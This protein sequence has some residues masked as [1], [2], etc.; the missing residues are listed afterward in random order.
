MPLGPEIYF[1]K[2][3]NNKTGI[4]PYIQTRA[5]KKVKVHL[6]KVGQNLSRSLSTTTMMTEY[7]YVHRVKVMKMLPQ[8]QKLMD[9][10]L[11]DH[12]PL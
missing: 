1:V 3:M 2:T 8:R 6:Y 10:T 11:R 7:P 5:V 9:I 4:K 12:Q